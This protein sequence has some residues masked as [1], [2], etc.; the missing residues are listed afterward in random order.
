M[1]TWFSTAM[2]LFAI[3]MLCWTT[4]PAS[5]A[6]D[7]SLGGGGG[8]GVAS[9]GAAMADFDTLINLIQQTVDP[10][11]WLAAGGTSTILQYPSGVYVDPKGH[12]KRMT[13]TEK[14]A[15]FGNAPQPTSN[16]TQHP[17]RNS[18]GLR[19]IS[20]KRLE[21]ALQRLASSGLPPRSEVIRLAGCR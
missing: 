9:G 21:S 8:T 14:I 12:V 1:R 13:E 16:S 3:A 18:S 6:Q 7:S 11:S 5:N 17:W 20:L 15:V 4:S 10:D 2:R 19:T